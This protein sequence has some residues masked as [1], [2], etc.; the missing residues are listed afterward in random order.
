MSEDPTNLPVLQFSSIVED[1]A[2]S[3]VVEETL[4]EEILSIPKYKNAISSRSAMSFFLHKDTQQKTH[5][6]AVTYDNNG[7]SVKIDDRVEDQVAVLLELWLRDQSYLDSKNYD[8]ATLVVTKNGDKYETLFDPCWLTQH[9]NVL[10]LTPN[11][12]NVIARK[13]NPLKRY[14]VGAFGI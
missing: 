9:F 6:M 2:T 13:L 12:R 5:F 10:E 4:L 7:K 14:T 3:G 11:S 8:M 1:F